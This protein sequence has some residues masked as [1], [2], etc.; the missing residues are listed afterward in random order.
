MKYIISFQII[1]VANKRR[2][3]SNLHLGLSILSVKF[4]LFR[5][6]FRFDP[7]ISDIRKFSKK[8]N[9]KNQFP[10]KS[11]QITNIKILESGYPLQS[12]NIQ[13]HVYI[14]YIQSYKCIKLYNY[15]SN[16]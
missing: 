2:T 12:G 13:I 15:Y 5:Y 16:I 11:K 3:W 1:N 14:D 6:L 4:D 7:K 10:L 8:I 9:I